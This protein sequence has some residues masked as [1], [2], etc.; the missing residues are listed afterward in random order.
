MADQRW[1]GSIEAK[2][3]MGDDGAGHCRGCG[4]PLDKLDVD[5][6]VCMAALNYLNGVP[7]LTAAEGVS[8]VA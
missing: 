3:A 7:I 8:D 4:N 2:R 5:C 6:A 1:V